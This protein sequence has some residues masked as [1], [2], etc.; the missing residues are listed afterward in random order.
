M[1]SG[2]ATFPADVQSVFSGLISQYHFQPEREEM[3]AV[4]VG[5][6]TVQL[7]FS[8]NEEVLTGYIKTGEGYFNILDWYRKQHTAEANAS[9]AALQQQIAHLHVSEYFVTYLNWYKQLI[10]TYLLTAFQTG[11]MPGAGEM[12]E[13]KV[14]QQI[15]EQEY[16]R[17]WGAMQ[18]LGYEDPIRKKYI[19]NDASWQADMLARL[20]Q[21]AGTG[22]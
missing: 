6:D 5:N 2:Y 10:N 18:Q 14:Q 19:A 21:S 3:D 9:F 12:Q 4:V 13:H 1:I 15:R 17:A 20:E 8:I 7:A 11:S 22:E 16:S